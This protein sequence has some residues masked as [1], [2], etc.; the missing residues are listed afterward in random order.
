MRK[1]INLFMLIFIVVTIPLRSYADENV[2][3]SQIYIK[4]NC[5]DFFF[6][7][8]FDM[9]NVRV[10]VSN[11]AIEPIAGGFVIDRKI[12][13]RT[14]VLLDVSTS[15]P[16]NSRDYAKAYIDY[17]IE[18]ISP[19][20]QL[21]LATF[22]DK[23]DI[24][25]DFTSDRYDLAKSINKIKYNG[26]QKKIYDAV[27]NIVSQIQPLEDVPI[28]YRTIVITDGID[29]TAGGI[30][31]E[32]LY[33]KLKSDRYPIDVI[34]VS[35]KVQA[36]PEKNL[37]A[38]T[39]VSGGR[40]VNIYPEA[41]IK[42][43]SSVL[44]VGEIF[45]IRVRIPEELLDGSTRQVDISDG[46]KSL[47]FDVKVPVS[48]VEMTEVSSSSKVTESPETSDSSRSDDKEQGNHFPSFI[49]FI[50]D[51]AVFLFFVTAGLSVIIIFIGVKIRRRSAQRLHRPLPPEKVDFFDEKTEY[52][53]DMDSFGQYTIKISDSSNPDKSWILPIV[54]ELI[55]GRS[56][57]A[58]VYI[59]DK[60][61]SR[62]QCK[63]IVQTSGPAVV[64]L[65]QTNKTLLN[66]V[67]VGGISPLKSGDIL[68]FGRCTLHIDYIQFVGDVS[69]SDLGHQSENDD[70]TESIF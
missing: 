21:R 11:K 50:G 19:Q 43:V 20:E 57:H 14:T 26:A 48:D 51:N 46:Q 31:K 6:F 59:D 47:Q 38:L 5:M 23:L 41:R 18:N 27:Y 40:Y 44:G 1:K 29:E 39:R 10:K 61:A 33:L 68:K 53:G 70:K 17:L 54:E 58:A 16:L 66:G 34:A 25:Q 49:Q 7:G 64:H 45:W 69:S 2:M 4:D 56:E 22:G 37:A 8:E 65:G 32:E 13:I 28:Y 30:T 55:V 67:K 62:E 12:A 35:S 42:D 60:S 52:L 15:F 3:L 63:I 9:S 36:E 24:L